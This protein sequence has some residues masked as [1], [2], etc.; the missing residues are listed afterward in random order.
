MLS[1]TQLAN[2]GNQEHINIAIDSTGLKI[3]GAGVWSETKHGLKKRRQWRKLHLTIDRDSHAIIAQE[4]TTNAETDDYLVEPMLN[5]I[6]QKVAHFSADKAYDK[7]HVYQAVHD[8]CGKDITI[9][10]PPI[11]NAVV[12]D[13]D[14]LEFGTRNHNV[15][16]IEEHGSYRW[17][18]HSD[19]NYRALVETAMFRYKTIINEKLFSRKFITQQAEARIACVVLNKM[20]S[21]GMPKS[22]KI[23]EAA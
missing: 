4:L 16:Y 8:K 3:F 21:L 9:A 19:Y 12:H 18:S 1:Y 7:H 20:T 23:L 2:I 10:I 5:N 13:E 11:T 6:T 22:V 17:Q 14:S 15:A